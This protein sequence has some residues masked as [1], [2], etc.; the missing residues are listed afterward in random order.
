MCDQEACED[1]VH[2]ERIFVISGPSGVGKNTLANELCR[3]RA[4]VRAVTATTRAPRD[5]EEDGQDYFFVGEDEFERRVE[6]GRLLE[7][8][9]YMGNRYG[10]PVDSLNRAARTGL[11]VILVIDVEGAMQ[12]QAC[13][14][15]AMLVFVLPPS[16]DELRRRLE[17][18]GKD[19][20]GEIDRRLE[21]AREECR[22]A[23][24][25]DVQVVNDEVGRAADR[26]AHIIAERCATDP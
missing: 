8:A 10:T 1:L 3:R 13:R 16:E 17:N 22:C 18:R 21:R 26:L 7:H 6:A 2:P 15:E 14:P 25:Y 5:G 23:G 4:V 24:S 20:P 9:R 11:P 19:S 12:V